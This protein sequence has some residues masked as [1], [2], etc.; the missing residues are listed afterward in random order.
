MSSRLS[1]VVILTTIL[2]LGFTA[3]ASLSY[4]WANQSADDKILED[5]LPLTGDN[6][7]SEI[8]KDLLQS[9]LVSS[10]MAQD[11]F[12]QSWVVQGEDNPEQIIRYLQSIQQ[13]YKAVTAFFISDKSRT[14]YHSSG[15]LKVISPQD[16]DDHWYFNVAKLKQNYEV[17]LDKDSAAPD[18]TTFFVNHKVITSDDVFLGVIGVGLSSDIVIKAI[19]AYQDR[20]QRTIY[21]SDKQGNIVL[22]GTSFQEVD[23]ISQRPGMAALTSS[24]LKQQAGSY[25]YLREK[26]NVFLST[27]FVPDL[28]WYLFVEQ[29]QAVAP[30]IIDALWFN[31]GISLV[32]TSIIVFL[33]ILKVNNY[34]RQIERLAGRDQLTKTLSRNSFEPIFENLI[35]DAQVHKKPMAVIL[36]DIDNFK[37]VNDRFGHLAGDE[38][39]AEVANIL[40]LNLRKSDIVC[41]WGGEEFLI[42]LLDCELDQAQA[43]AEKKRLLIEAT[44]STSDNNKVTASFG[45]AKLAKGD[46][47]KKLFSRA[48]KALYQAKN[49]GRNRVVAA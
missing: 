38:V 44:I 48:D 40:K 45:V 16:P 22:H 34:Q 25:T 14:Y 43:I 41:R 18:R 2:L 6:I 37:Q 13:R 7:Y 36:M 1:F 31:L 46:C 23:N 26:A 28:N 39:L 42:S 49:E 4:L 3:S 17:N 27:R 33:T 8:Q 12:V 35:N 20:Y 21:F 32:F 15:V 5:T 10:L 24:I 47:S 29:Q 30:K 19:D 9:I 11:T